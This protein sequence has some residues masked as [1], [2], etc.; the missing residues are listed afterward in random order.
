MM[1]LKYKPGYHKVH[2][3]FPHEEL[4]NGRLTREVFREVLA[5]ELKASGR[6]LT[7]ITFTD[8]STIITIKEPDGLCSIQLAPRFPEEGI[9]LKQF[10][11]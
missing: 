10:R 5:Q 2:F 6:E 4:R 11:R 1:A 9:E 3:N 8:L 7:D